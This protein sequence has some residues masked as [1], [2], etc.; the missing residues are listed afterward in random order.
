MKFNVTVHGCFIVYL[1]LLVR[2]QAEVLVARRE[3]DRYERKLKKNLGRY[4]IA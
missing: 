2:L 1:V 3:K 4:G